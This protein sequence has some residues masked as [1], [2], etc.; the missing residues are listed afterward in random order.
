MRR[1]V[2]RGDE[3]FLVL[4]PEDSSCLGMTIRPGGFLVP[5]NDNSTAGGHKT[6]PYR[7]SVPAATIRSPISRIAAF[8]D[9][10]LTTCTAK[11]NAPILDAIQ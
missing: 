9:S 7:L 3:G 11:G 2:E 5:R 8:S 4:E 10:D 6:L 1:G